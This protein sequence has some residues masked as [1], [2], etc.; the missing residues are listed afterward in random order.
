MLESVG[1]APPLPPEHTHLRRTYAL[2]CILVQRSVTLQSTLQPSTDQLCAALSMCG[3][4]KT[5]RATIECRSKCRSYYRMSPLRCHQSSAAGIH[6]FPHQWLFVG[7]RRSSPTTSR[8]IFAPTP[9]HLAWESMRVLIIPTSVGSLY[10]LT[11]YWGS[12]EDTHER[13]LQNILSI[14]FRDY[15]D[16]QEYLSSQLSKH[17]FSSPEG[18]NYSFCI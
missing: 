9:K 14:G 17:M 12:S 7:E 11:A 1:A 16:T 2:Q 5:V 10:L 4:Q 6:G 18:Q 3:L 15:E 8:W 13:R